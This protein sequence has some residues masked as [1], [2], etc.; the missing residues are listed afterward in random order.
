MNKRWK[1]LPERFKVKYRISPDGC[2]IWTGAKGC[3]GYGTIMLEGKRIT[4]P[5]AS[6][7]I[8]YGCLEPGKWVLHKC[9]NPPCCNPAHLFLGTQ[10]DN[11][12]DMFA[13][14]RCNARPTDGTALRTRP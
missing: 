11:V 9:D 12:R 8:R 13:K 6:M 5:H 4:A 1:P 2:W 14:G 3:R 10:V 7:I